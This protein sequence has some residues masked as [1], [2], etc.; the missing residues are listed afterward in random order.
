KKCLKN[1]RVSIEKYRQLLLGK[2]P[3]HS[4]ALPKSPKP[5][6]PYFRTTTPSYIV[7]LEPVSLRAL[8]S[9][10]A[11]F[12]SCKP[13]SACSS[14]VMCRDTE[15]ICCRPSHTD[16]TPLTAVSCPAPDILTP[17]CNKKLGVSWC[18]K[19]ID[20]HTP[21]TKRKCCPTACNYNICV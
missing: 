2:K 15:G 4:K 5:I 19:D 14:S 17:Q 7:D 18:D 13:H 16:A 1:R 10:R 12:S 3:R 9:C 6:F 21:V 8:G 11:R 20:C